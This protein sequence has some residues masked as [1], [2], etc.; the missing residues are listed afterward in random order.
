MN[1]KNNLAIQTHVLSK[2]FGEI[3][4]L[5]DL[6]LAVPKN[7][8]VGFLGPNGAGKTTAIRLL[9]GLNQPTSGSGRIFGLD[10]QI[11]LH[12]RGFNHVVLPGHFH[13]NIPGKQI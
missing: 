1:P 5:R 4:A 7:S 10:I 9:L 12:Q 2:S 11:L 6:D 13:L 3:Q 8:I